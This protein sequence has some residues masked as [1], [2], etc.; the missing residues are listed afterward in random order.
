MNRAAKTTISVTLAIAMLIAFSILPVPDGLSRSGMETIGLIVFM[1]A[2]WIGDVVPKAVSGLAVLALMPILGVTDSF[3]EAF[4]GFANSVLFFLLAS[5]AIA[6]AVKNSNIPQKLMV[7]FL[8]LSKGSSSRM[9]LAYMISAAIVSSVMSDLAAC[10][11]MASTAFA[12]FD[13]VGDHLTFDKSFIKAVLIGIPMASLSGG[14][15][16]PIGSSSNITMIELMRQFSGMEV[17]FLSWMIVGVPLAV[18]S[19]FVGWAALM[20]SL[21]PK[22]LGAEEREA[23]LRSAADCSFGKSD[24]KVIVVLGAMFVLWV[25]S[26]WIDWLDSTHIAVC[27]LIVMFLPGVS[28]ITWK[29]YESEVPWNMVIMLCSVMALSEKLFD[30]GAIDW[31]VSS[32]FV[33]ADSWN[34]LI[35]LLTIGALVAFLRA[36]IPS[37]P[38][39]VVMLTP[40]FLALA[41]T[42]HLDPLCVVMAMSTWAQITYLV[43][44]VD[45][46]YLITY[47]HGYYRAV[48]VF[49]MGIPLTIGLL[50]L[51]TAITPALVGVAEVVG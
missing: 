19:V 31:V 32:V 2:L 18:L 17:S 41:Q 8:R 20:I 11:L 44:Q 36:F 29:E 49:R 50:F 24:V 34:P 48:D 4:E 37:G 35:M 46:L 47:S 9:I 23:L 25:A 26:G 1:F 33:G 28:L 15:S 5:F 21:K 30:T 16:T 3:S 10:A 40:A 39:V 42:V 27:G 45:A 6:A 22:P 43:P 12:V 7:F 38:P 14:I 13:K 51:F